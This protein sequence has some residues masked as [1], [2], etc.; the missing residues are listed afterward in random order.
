MSW[1]VTSPGQYL[2]NNWAKIK[3]QE[4]K[5]FTEHRISGDSNIKF[6]RWGIAEK[7]LPFLDR[8]W[9]CS[10]LETYSNRPVPALHLSPPMEHLEW[11]EA[12]ITGLKMF[13]QKQ[14][15]RVRKRNTSR[16]HEKPLDTLTGYM[17]N[18]INIQFQTLQNPETESSLP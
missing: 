18:P 5:A 11:S 15:G 3:T 10:L 1:V 12:Y 9:Q 8:A 6:A 14:R 7:S 17:L 4:V 16:Q 2:D 13:P